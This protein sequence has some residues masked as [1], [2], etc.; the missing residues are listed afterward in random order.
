MSVLDEILD[1]VRVD[2]AERQARTPLDDLKEA[3]RHAPEALD[4]MPVFRS[5][6]YAGDDPGT[7]DA[8]DDFGIGL[9]LFLS[10]LEARVAAP[11]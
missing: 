7:G 9:E 10:G 6:G 8:T 4:P 3:A 5:G 11:R 1:G 2:L